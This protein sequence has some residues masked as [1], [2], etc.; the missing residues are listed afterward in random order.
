MIETRRL[1]NVIIFIQA[2]LS[3]IKYTYCPYC[4]CFDYKSRK[5]C[6]L[7]FIVEDFSDFEEHLPD[8]IFD[9]DILIDYHKK[10]A[11]YLRRL[12]LAKKT[13]TCYRTYP[14]GQL[15][16]Y[17]REEIIEQVE[18]MKLKNTDSEFYK[19]LYKK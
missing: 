8:N 10:L 11:P 7:C 12:F 1:K 2:I 14:S 3:Q 19:P 16:T 6:E 5:K 9:K 15:I 18:E 13:A 4:F 17:H